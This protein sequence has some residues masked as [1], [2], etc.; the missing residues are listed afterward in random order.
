MKKGLEF[1][2]FDQRKGQK[3]RDYENRVKKPD[4]FDKNIGKNYK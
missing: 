3:N 4:E 1:R 2:K